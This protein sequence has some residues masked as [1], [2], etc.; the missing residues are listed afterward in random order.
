[1][2]DSLSAVKRAMPAAFFLFFFISGMRRSLEN[3]FW[4]SGSGTA[5]AK[6]VFL[7]Y[8]IQKKLFL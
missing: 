8:H 4:F 2:K 1:M 3:G 5:C 7:V 6:L